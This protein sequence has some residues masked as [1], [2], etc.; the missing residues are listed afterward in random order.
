MGAWPS[1]L[2]TSRACGIADAFRTVGKDLFLPLDPAKDR[3]FL[4]THRRC[5]PNCSGDTS[6][7][8]GFART[9]RS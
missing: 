1:F 6:R 3:L 4:E 2:P 5:W 7:R 8:D 9:A